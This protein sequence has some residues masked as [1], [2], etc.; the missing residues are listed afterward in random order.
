M[1]RV[2]EEIPKDVRALHRKVRELIKAVNSKTI[3][4]IQIHTQSMNVGGTFVPI[5]STT[6]RAVETDQGTWIILEP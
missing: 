1:A 6:G 3:I 5:P 4:G 2:N